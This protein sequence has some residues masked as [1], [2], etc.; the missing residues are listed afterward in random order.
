M[1][2]ADSEPSAP[3]LGGLCAAGRQPRAEVLWCYRPGMAAVDGL[4]VA[5]TRRILAQ[6]E[7][8]AGR[9]V[10]P[11]PFSVRAER[12]YFIV[13]PADPAPPQ[14]LITFRDWLLRQAT[15]RL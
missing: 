7:L 13:H 12:S 5:L 15:Q 3:L 10:R 1:E 8:E 6:P 11:V 2:S 4:G 9:L 14:R